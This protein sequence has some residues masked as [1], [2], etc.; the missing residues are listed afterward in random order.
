MP[1]TLKWAAASATEFNTNLDLGFILGGT[2]AGA[3]MTAIL[4]NLARDQCF[5]PPLTGLY[6]SIPVIYAPFFVPGTDQHLYLSQKQDMGTPL[7]SH[8]ANEMFLKALAL[9]ENHPYQQMFRHSETHAGLPPTY[10]Q[11]CG[12]DPIRDDALAYERTLRKEHGIRTKVD[13]YPGLPHAF[14]VFLPTF[15]ATKKFRQDQLE[16]LGWLPGRKP[17]MTKIAVAAE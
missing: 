2:S 9:D 5:S 15:K 14:W 3:N 16:G 7:L 10:F 4:A 11:V 17:D 1:G 12:M 6:M 8:E 13:V